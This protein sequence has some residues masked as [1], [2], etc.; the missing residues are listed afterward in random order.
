[1]LRR[2]LETLLFGDFK[3]FPMETRLF[4][5]LTILAMACSVAAAVIN[6]VTGLS[7]MSV[8]LTACMALIS[9]AVYLYTRINGNWQRIVIYYFFLIL[10]AVCVL[11][12]FSGG[13]QGAIGACFL[14]FIPVTVVC[15]KDKY[16]LLSLAVVDLVILALLIVEFYHPE[17]VVPYSGKLARF[18]DIASSLSITIVIIGLMVYVLFKEFQAEREAVVKAMATKQRL[19]AMVS[20]DISNA[21]QFITMASV[22]FNL[23]AGQPRS[24][25]VTELLEEIKFGSANIGQIIDT[26]RMVEA[27]E[28]GK[29]A[30]VPQKV[31]ILDIVSRSR[32]MFAARLAEK[33]IRL[34]FLC[35]EKTSCLVWAD[36]NSLCNNV[37]GNILSNAIKYSYPGSVI[38]VGVK[39]LGAQTALS[40]SDRGL[41]M[42]KEIKDNLFTMNVPTH[43]LGTNKETGTGFGMLVVKGLVDL[44]GGRIDIASIA[45]EN[46]PGDHGTTVTIYLNAVSV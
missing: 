15:L 41:G 30:F 9:L 31:D 32:M 28:T 2:K 34:E 17:L 39:V 45:K 25:A 33:N 13:T 29:T 14:M 4:Y 21:L 23:A 10:A 46:A 22:N 8:V 5:W 35:P 18:I 38:T 7:Y 16:K 11:W 37:L 1:M 43:R 27:V 26:V 42:P 19:L 3:S 12:F 20:H 40:V 44:Y 6:F 24:E 36:S